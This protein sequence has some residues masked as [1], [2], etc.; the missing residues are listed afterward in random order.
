MPNGEDAQKLLRAIAPELARVRRLRTATMAHEPEGADE[1]E[2]R[3]RIVA[4]LIAQRELVGYLYADL[5]GAFGR[6][7]ESDRDLLGML[8]SQGAVALANAQW[9]QGLEQKVVQRTNE[10]QTSNAL[11]EQRAGE[12]AI[13]NSIQQGMA[14]ELDFQAI[15]DLVGDKLREVFKTGDIGIRWYD[16]ATDT[17]LAPYDYEHGVRLVVQPSKPKPASPWHRLVATRQP[18]VTNS[19]AEAK[20][21]GA[22]TIPGTDECLSSV[23]IPILGGDRVLGSIILE[24]FEREYAYG[25]AEVRVLSTVAASMGVA[26]ENARLFD[27]TQRLFKTEQQRAAELAIINSVQGGWRRNSIFRPSSI[28]SARKFARSL[29]HRT[30]RSRCAMR[31]AACW[32]C[33]TIWNTASDFP[34]SPFPRAALP[35]MSSG[36][37]SRWSSTKTSCSAPLSSVQL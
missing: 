20:A 9:S 21:L 31:A 27:E 16:A 4:P 25:E 29:R 12:L 11:L 34:W 18:I 10:L 24:S 35:A 26:L 19:P 30:C 14:A 1:L 5:D 7:R 22:T 2:Q 28:S 8:A 3:S 23:R 36:L 33:P 6:F 37:A 15:I 32:R 17:L 13:I